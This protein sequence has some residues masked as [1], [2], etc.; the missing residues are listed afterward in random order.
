[1]NP[2]IQI[3]PITCHPS[4]CVTFV[5][6]GSNEGWIDQ[7]L[8][9]LIYMEL[10]DCLYRP[11]IITL[12]VNSLMGFLYSI[13]LFYFV[14]SFLVCFLISFFLISFLCLISF[15][16]F[17]SQTQVSCMY[18]FVLIF[19]RKFTNAFSLFCC[20]FKYFISIFF[21]AKWQNL[22]K[23]FFYFRFR[24]HCFRFFILKV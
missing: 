24:N 10:D 22:I 2:L 4:L 21:F 18:L 13:F 15:F 3:D 9:F 1:M 14:V 7:C 20:C 19:V 23:P 6:A 12:Q 8:I 16:W 17:V 5:N 11:R